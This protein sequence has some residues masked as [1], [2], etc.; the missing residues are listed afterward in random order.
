[1]DRQTDGQ[2]DTQGNGRMDTT[3]FPNFFFPPD[4]MLFPGK[5]LRAFFNALC[6]RRGGEGR[7]GEDGDEWNR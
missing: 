5:A 4:P 2:M 1:M 6:E 3:H 7:G